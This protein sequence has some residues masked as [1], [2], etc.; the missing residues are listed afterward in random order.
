[1]SGT[2]PVRAPCE[3]VASRRIGS[4]HSLTVVAPEIA[5]RTEPGQFV[6]IAVEGDGTLLR[7]PFSISAVRDLAGTVEMTFEANGRGTVWLAGRAQHDVI[8]VVG[9]LGH[10]FSLPR[11]PVGCLLVGGGYGA[12]PL[13]YLAS[14]LR[15]RELRVDMILGAA[16]RR[17]LY[18][19]VTA[20]RVSDATY[21]VTEDGSSG[22][23]G[24]VTD[25]MDR[26]LDSRAV[27]IVYACGPMPMLAAVSK[28]ATGR[29]IP[30]QVAVEEAMACGVGVCWTCVIP[31]LSKGEVR[32]VRAC[33][34]GPC[35]NGSRVLWDQIGATP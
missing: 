24:R 2:G 11:Q 29:E 27:G 12:A 22:T 18:N 19:T 25:V 13:L 4:Y 28:I 33:V 26:V 6:S 31:Y 7:R 35:L 1:M 20:R 34:E 30:V 32:N 5:A 9:P 14:Q 23:K 10:P 3:V 17:R 16:T 8:D 15:R 21:P